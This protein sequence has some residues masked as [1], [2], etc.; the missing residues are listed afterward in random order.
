MKRTFLSCLLLAGSVFQAIGASYDNNF[1]TASLGE[2]PSDFLVLDG[3]F[4]VKE[5]N[6]NKFLELPGAPLDTYGL[7]FGPTEKENLTVSARMFGTAKGRRFPTFSIGSHGVGGYKLQVSPG[8]KA[9]ELFKGDELL[10]SVP[11]EWQSGQWTQLELMVKRNAE[12]LALSGRA[13]TGQAARP[14]E[15][16]ITFQDKTPAAAGRAAISGSPYSGTPIRF[17]DLKVAPA[18]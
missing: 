6:G 7:L 18:S 16:Q 4:S 1:E 8:K 11:F 17:D 3:A 12:G 2:P 10:A 13:W 14:A 9:L 5:E 15:A